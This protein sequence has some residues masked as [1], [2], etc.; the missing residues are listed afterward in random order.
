MQRAD[1]LTVIRHDDTTTVHDDVRYT[2]TR[3]GLQILDATGA[4]TTVPA[5]DLLTTHASATH[6]RTPD[7]GT[8]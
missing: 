1:R 6:T 2:L 4:E 5:F 3:E 7:G 8:R